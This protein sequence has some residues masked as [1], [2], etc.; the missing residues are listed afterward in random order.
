MPSS[1]EILQKAMHDPTLESAISWSILEE[2]HRILLNS[3]EAPE[4]I[5]ISVS[6]AEFTQHFMNVEVIVFGRNHKRVLDIAVAERENYWDNEDDDRLRYVS[7]V[8]GETAFELGGDLQTG[9]V[10]IVFW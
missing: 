6:D 5:H 2:L 10:Q 8:R 1:A 4:S 3:E 9:T 7:Q